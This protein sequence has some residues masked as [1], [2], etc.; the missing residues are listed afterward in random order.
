MR[1]ADFTFELPDS[2]IARHPLAERRNSRL[3]TLDG[4]SGVLA[5]VV[6]QVGDGERMN[7]EAADRQ[8]RAIDRQRRDDGV[9]ARAV[10][11][12][13]VDHRARFVHA[14]A[15]ARN[16]FLDDLHQVGVNHTDPRF[17]DVRVR[18]AILY[19]IDRLGA[20]NAVVV[21]AVD[22]LGNESARVKVL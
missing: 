5:A 15:H 8:D 10:R 9:H 16:D 14:P 22:R 6:E 7:G 11:Q 4:E 13:G 2:L 19:A 20:A 21:S 1:V 12:A 3:L 17:Q 18:Q